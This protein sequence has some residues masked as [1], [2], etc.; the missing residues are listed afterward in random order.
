MTVAKEMAVS[1]RRF[2]LRVLAGIPVS[3]ASRSCDHPRSFSSSRILVWVFMIVYP[4][5]HILGIYQY[6]LSYPDLYSGSTRAQETRHTPSIPPSWADA[7]CALEGVMFPKRHC[8]QFGRYFRPLRQRLPRK[9]R[10]LPLSI[11]KRMARYE[12]FPGQ[13]RT[14]SV[15]LRPIPGRNQSIELIASASRWSVFSWWNH[16]LTAECDWQE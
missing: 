1:P 11:R 13:S 8:T 7:S 2:R 5:Q 6:A 16:R 9:L 15:R 12:S 14:P 3:S 4:H 10:V